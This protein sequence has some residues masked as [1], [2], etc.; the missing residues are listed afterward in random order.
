M[1]Q[2]KLRGDFAFY[3]FRKGREETVYKVTFRVRTENGVVFPS[4]FVASALS[5]IMAV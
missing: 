3:F 4:V 2:T 5:L 1:K